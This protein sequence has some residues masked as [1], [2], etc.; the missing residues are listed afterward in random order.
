M[1][2]N[3][4]FENIVRAMKGAVDGSTI[5][6]EAF[7]LCWRDKGDGPTAIEEEFLLKERVARLIPILQQAFGGKHEEK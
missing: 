5:T 6:A 7:Q 4:D 3:P 1:N 2:N